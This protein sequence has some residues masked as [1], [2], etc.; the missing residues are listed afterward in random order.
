MK[1][2]NGEEERP[3]RERRGGYQAA[4]ASFTAAQVVG[5]GALL[6]LADQHVHACIGSYIAF[7]IHVKFFLH[8]MCL[9]CLDNC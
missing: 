5:R 8:C 6:V 7:Y 4:A 2:K 9:T 3:H 1:R